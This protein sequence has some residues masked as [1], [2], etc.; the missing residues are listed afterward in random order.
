MMG[1]EESDLG[2][3]RVIVITLAVYAAGFGLWWILS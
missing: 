3:A 2:L 1:E